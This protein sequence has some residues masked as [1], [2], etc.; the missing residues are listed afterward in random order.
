MPFVPGAEKLQQFRLTCRP[1]WEKLADMPAEDLAAEGG[2]CRTLKAFYALIGKSPD[3]IVA[4]I[5]FQAL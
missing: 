4:V 2:M 1:Y 5:R 3:D